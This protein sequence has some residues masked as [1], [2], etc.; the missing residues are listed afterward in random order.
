MSRGGQGRF[1]G[2]RRGDGA[3]GERDGGVVEEESRSQR[4]LGAHGEQH[5]AG[6]RAGRQ[7]QETRESELLG[8]AR[9]HRPSGVALIDA[10]AGAG[11]GM[12]AL[13]RH[14]H[15]HHS[16]QRPPRI[17]GVEWTRC[18]RRR[19]RLLVP[20]LCIS[21]AVRGRGGM[22][23][24][25]TTLISPY[26]HRIERRSIDTTSRLHHLAYPHFAWHA[27]SRCHGC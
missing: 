24:A 9:Y 27:C 22:A 10:L 3:E 4:V 21:A 13:G 11:A 14:A 18:C 7:A 1:A 6:R 16:R 25:A 26:S 20:R 23:L 15:P 5:M 8:C 19:R 12:G 17:G 2:A